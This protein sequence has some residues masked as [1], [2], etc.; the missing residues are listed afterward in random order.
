[1]HAIL[2][3]RSNRFAAVC[4]SALMVFGT[5]ILFCSSTASAK[6]KW[7]AA[8]AEELAASKPMIDPDAPAEVLSWKISVDDRN[9][10]EYRDV[11]EYLRY[12]VFDP[13]KADH[14]MRLSQQAITVDGVEVREA[15]MSARLTQP[16]G[17]T[18]EYGAESVRERDVV[19]NASPDSALRKLFS[20]EG[21]S[22]KEK[23]LAV[24]GVQPGAVLE[25][26]IKVTERYPR[27]ATLRTLQIAG[28]SVR[29]LEYVQ[30]PSPEVDHYR[31][32]FFV[33]NTD[34]KK[35]KEDKKTGLITLAAEN[36]RPLSDEPLSGT[37]P[38]YAVTVASCY[39]HTQ[40]YSM[41]G[42][43]HHREFGPDQPWAPFATVTSWI[44]QDHIVLT[45]AVKKKAAE[46]TSDAT[47]PVEKAVRIHD[48]VQQLYQRFF[49]ER[50]SRRPVMINLA[51][52]VNMDDVMDFEKHEPEKMRD[53][54][55][56]WLAVSLYRAAGLKSELLMLPNRR[57]APFSEKLVSDAFLPEL[58]VA[59]QWDDAWHFSLPTGRIPVAFDQLPWEL[60]GGQGL[61]AREGRQDFLRIPSTAGAA[62][63]MAVT[64][65]LELHPDGSLTGECK[66][67]LSGEEA[68]ASRAFLYTRPPE[69][70]RSA[71]V[72]SLRRA[73]P[74]A[75]IRV[76]DV[77]NV[78]DPAKPV[79]ITYALRWPS[80]ATST[81]NRLIFR[82][83]VFRTKSTSPFTN[84]ERH[85]SI[86]FPFARS[87]D[88]TYTLK[89]PPG[90]KL[91]AKVAPAGIPG[92]ALSYKI[93]IGYAAKTDTLHV[94]REFVSELSVV[95]VQVYPDLKRWYDAVAASDQY[96]LVLVREAAAASEGGSQPVA[97]PDAPM[98][99]DDE[100]D[101]PPAE[102]SATSKP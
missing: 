46:L 68:Y 76:Q 59:V 93:G 24:G 70:R 87:E 32:A 21:F 2:P 6:D 20:S 102:S 77:A 55:F 37:P 92:D 90:F 23:F 12:K 4:A 26:R 41:K 66:L 30:Q 11:S 67:A 71:V 7:E 17:T 101:S 14:L 39:T 75:S 86:Y 69:K 96:E 45:A 19:R 25:F 97:V 78:D 13:E 88:D 16:D 27:P 73:L 34:G 89:L 95:P 65:K 94:H 42:N 43:S 33:L 81:E 61:F 47:S 49:R 48:Y 79:E 36:L 15:E 38:Y 82:P 9:Y 80:F 57:V 52:I 84:A 44:S 54:D 100:P 58:C 51:D 50:K 53:R 56:T 72:A 62:S 18:K 10:P 83:L 74:G 3:A 63:R 91:E 60:R 64:G 85:N 99:P 29:R 40:L 1:M 22:V 28:L 98:K 8:S 5:A 35:L 31:H